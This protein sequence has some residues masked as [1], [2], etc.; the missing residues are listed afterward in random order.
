MSRFARVESIEALMDFRASMCTFADTA[1]SGLSGADAH[2]RKTLEWLKH[3]QHRYWKKEMRKR[4]EA[5]TQAKSALNAK[6][7]YKTPTGGNYSCVEEEKALLAA[8]ARYDEA[9]RKFENVRRWIRDLEQERLLYK[10]QTQRASHAVDVGIPK[11]VAQLDKMIVALEA[12]VALAPPAGRRPSDGESVS[13]PAAAGEAPPS[14][15]RAGEHAPGDDEVDHAAL[16]ERT[17]DPEAETGHTDRPDAD[18]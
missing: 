10:G 14:V 11:A 5:V 9:C 7:L 2:I 6:K 15:A 17:P 3:E 4:G 16:R 18:N 1:R 8:K 12:Y 13:R